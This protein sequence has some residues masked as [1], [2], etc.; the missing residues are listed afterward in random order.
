MVNTLL[1]GPVFRLNI[2]VLIKDREGIAVFEHPGRMVCGRLRGDNIKTIL[3]WRGGFHNV[4][5]RLPPH[6]SVNFSIFSRI[7]N[8]KLIDGSKNTIVN[9]GRN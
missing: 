3:D 6:Y 8:Q 9:I 5:C 2:A 4:L 7:I 1:S